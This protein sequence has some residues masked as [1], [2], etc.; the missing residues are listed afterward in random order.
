M[1]CLLTLK[2]SLLTLL[3]C[4]SAA[5]STNGV[6]KMIVHGDYGFILAHRPALEPLQEA[7]VKGFQLTMSRCSNGKAYWQEAF[8]YP[9]YGITLAVFDLGS[10]AKL[11]TGITVYPFIDFP[12]GKNGWNNFHFRYGMGIGYVEKTF[13]ANDNIKNAAIGSHI[14]GVI[15]F[16]LHYSKNITGRTSLELGSGITHYSNGSYSLPNLGIN[17]A[18]V[19]LGIQHT[20]GAH[21]EILHPTKP[22]YNKTTQFHI[23]TGGF[24]K[25]V[26]PPN[27][28]NYFAA[29]VSGLI[30]K[31][32]NLKSALGFGAD[33]FYDNSIARRIEDLN[34]TK[35]E[36]I[37]NFRSGIYGAYQLSIGKLGLMFNMG[38]Y[39]YN[40]W[41]ADGN[42]YH[43]IC[44]RYYFEKIFLCMNLKTHYARADFIELGAGIRIQRH[45]K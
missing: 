4:A 32:L 33:I 35:A 20:F 29:T 17:I 5:D 40:E 8:L 34:G 36:Q 7:H 31:P 21:Q 26:Y 30:F 9:D 16:D 10:H 39:L 45:K 11:G 42:I 41:K 25:R 23:Y 14:N 43:R 24:I 15:H 38:Y 44:V 13:D 37:K 3:A 12:L 22:E 6:W 19:N 28:R 1:R 2:F 27:G 18:T